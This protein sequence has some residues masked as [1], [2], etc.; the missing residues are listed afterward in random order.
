[1]PNKILK[2]YIVV[3]AAVASLIGFFWLGSNNSQPT[4]SRSA[5][6]FPS[7]S[8][9]LPGGSPEANTA[10]SCHSRYGGA[11]VTVS[12]EWC[13]EDK[14]ISGTL[15]WFSSNTGDYDLWY[16]IYLEL[17]QNAD[18]IATVEVTADSIAKL[19]EK[20]TADDEGIMHCAIL[21][22]TYYPVVPAGESEGPLRWKITGVVRTGRIT[23]DSQLL[24][25][26]ILDAMDME[27][28][29]VRCPPLSSATPPES[30]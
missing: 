9:G 12:S 10:P 27:K 25:R 24:Q 8:T 23:E 21:L 17:D 3:G 26:C 11:S 28:M 1:M 20:L 2:A 13:E 7:P 4:P 5:Q 14:A 6:S 22:R 15:L 18:A 16:T 30:R 19:R 29:G